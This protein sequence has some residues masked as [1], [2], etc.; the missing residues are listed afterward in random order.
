[1]KLTYKEHKIHLKSTFRTTHGASDE[2]TAIII[3]IDGGLGEAA[4]VHYYGENIETVK[5]FLDK[6][7][8]VLGDDPFELEGLG[9]KLDRVAAWD[10]SAKA[11]IDIA[12]HDK[13]CKQ[14]GI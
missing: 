9:G 14:L 13:I 1:M 7:A 2:K 3:D 6:A 12:M 4:P 11:A 8:K 10:F 5:V